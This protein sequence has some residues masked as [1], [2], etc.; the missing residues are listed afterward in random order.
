MTQIRITHRTVLEPENKYP[1][2]SIV[3]YPGGLYLNF[4]EKKSVLDMFKKIKLA[5]KGTPGSR[6]KRFHIKVE[7]YVDSI[8]FFKK[9]S[10]TLMVVSRDLE[11]AAELLHDSISRKS[12][13]KLSAALQKR[14]WTSPARWHYD[15]KEDFERLSDNVITHYFKKSYP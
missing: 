6:Y 1:I 13:R 2:K 15:S 11:A 12:Y 10:G 5:S 14:S 3:V 9:A 7:I 8:S 4:R